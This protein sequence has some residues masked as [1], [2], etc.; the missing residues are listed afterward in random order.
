M[1]NIMRR[2]QVSIKPPKYRL[3]RGD[4][5]I[6]IAGK[7]KG[8]TGE[9]NRIFRKIGK[10]EIPGIN[11]VRKHVKQSNE[12]PKGDIIQMAAKIDI[13]NVMLYCPKCKKGTRTSILI[14]KDKKIRICKKCGHQYK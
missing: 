2:K 14:E 11:L 12:R 1:R 7:D 5:V 6:V 8:K 9:I 13:S 4:K 10:V 3:K